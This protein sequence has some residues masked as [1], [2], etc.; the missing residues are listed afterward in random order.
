MIEPKTVPC[1][2]CGKPTVYTATKR[3]HNCWE[4]EGRLADYI[5]SPGGV[6]FVRKHLPKLDDWTDGKPGWDY[7]KVLTDNDVCV[8][9]CDKITSDGQTFE[10]APPNL[11]GWG[12]S[13]VHGSIHIGCTTEAIAREAAALFVS[14]WL[15]GVSASFCDKLMGGYIEFLERQE[16]TRLSFLSEIDHTST[17]EKFFRL[18]REDF[19]CRESFG[20]DAERKI[21]EV[22]ASADDEEIIV[23][24]MKRKK[25][26]DVWSHIRS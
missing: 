15:R 1:L 18:T 22:L 16:G 6:E 8:E 5:K 9:W 12:F 26:H 11:C 25:S 21:I 2:T 4:V 24:F 23:T 17:G 14:V 7:E 3:C 10:Q 19:C 13:W 20:S